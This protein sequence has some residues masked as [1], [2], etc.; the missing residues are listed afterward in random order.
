MLATVATMMVSWRDKISYTFQKVMDMAG[1]LYRAKFDNNAGL[2]GAEKGALLTAIVL[3]RETH[4]SY[5][6]SGLKSLLEKH[7]PLW[8]TTDEQS[9]AGFSI[10]ARIITGIF[11]DGTIDCTSLRINDSADGKQ[12]TET[13]KTFMEK[14]EE[15]TG[16]G[17]LRIQIVHF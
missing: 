16:T 13:F 14:F 3:T 11:G 5:T 8:A 9:G 17:K 1:S 10:H 4:M 6:V 12:Y 7:G 15:V 2:S